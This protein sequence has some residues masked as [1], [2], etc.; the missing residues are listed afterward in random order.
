MQQY[1]EALDLL[2]NQFSFSSSQE[3]IE[4]KKSQNT[5]LEEQNNLIESINSKLK[6]CDLYK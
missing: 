1:S 3:V 2:S 5:K 6:N 4:M